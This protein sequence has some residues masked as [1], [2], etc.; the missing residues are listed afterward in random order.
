[1][2]ILELPMLFGLLIS[3][4]GSANGGPPLYPYMG[5]TSPEFHR[6]SLQVGGTSIPLLLPGGNVTVEGNGM[7]HQHW[8]TIAL[9]GVGYSLS[10]SLFVSMGDQYGE[11]NRFYGSVGVKFLPFKW[12][13]T[14]PGYNH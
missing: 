6:L 14:L 13:D 2:S 9:V 10:K 8:R 4:V 11:G 7:V 3:P 1:M 5:F 12:E